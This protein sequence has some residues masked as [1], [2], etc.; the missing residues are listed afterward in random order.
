MRYPEE[1]LLLTDQELEFYGGSEIV[2]LF[3]DGCFGQVVAY[4]PASESFVAFWV[5]EGLD[6]AT[7]PRLV[8]NQ[9]LLPVFLRVYESELE[10]DELR[11]WAKRLQFGY[12]EE[13]VA[14]YASGA[15][16][17]SRTHV[18]WREELLDRM[19]AENSG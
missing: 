17:S 7:C 6:L 10:D 19:A 8:W 4:H 14:H 5:E 11:L 16:A 3:Y 13:I 1:I 9:V 15:A 12:A 18:P 2:P